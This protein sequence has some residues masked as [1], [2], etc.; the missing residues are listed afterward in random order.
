MGEHSGGGRAGTVPWS[1]GIADRKWGVTMS[2][3]QVPE[4]DNSLLVHL[5][6]PQLPFIFLLCFLT[7]LGITEHSKEC[8]HLLPPS[9]FRTEFKAHVETL[10]KS[11]ILA[12]DFLCAHDCAKNFLCLIPT[13]IHSRTEALGLFPLYR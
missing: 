3:G 11:Q 7:F 12:R 10:W 1:Q 4:V 6:W 2:Q 9:A 8:P 13:N 5:V